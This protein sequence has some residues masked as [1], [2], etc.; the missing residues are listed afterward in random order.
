MDR[1][2]IT[3]ARRCAKAQSV[4]VGQ[5]AHHTAICV[6]GPG[7]HHTATEMCYGTGSNMLCGMGCAGEHIHHPP[8]DMEMCQGAGW[9][10]KS[11]EVLPWGLLPKHKQGQRQPHPGKQAVVCT[12]G[13]GGGLHPTNH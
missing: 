8:G 9:D 10:M 11:H 5:E 6:G 7:A 3:Q 12:E 1:D 4:W 13:Y 2:S